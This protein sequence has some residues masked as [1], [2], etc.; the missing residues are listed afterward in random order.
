MA[1]PKVKLN[2]GF[3]GVAVIEIHNP[4]V[5]ALAP[6]VLLGLKVSFDEAHRRSDVKAIVVTGTNGKFSG[7]FD[8][9]AIVAVQEQG[10]MDSMVR[11]SVPLFVETIEG[12]S[13][14][15]VAAV[16]G[17]ALGGGLE[18]ALSC[19]ARIAAPKA[20]LGLPEL[21]LGIIPGFGG[22][23]RL[24]RLVGLQKAIEMILMSKPITSEAGLKAGLVDQIV[25]S[26]A[27]LAT[28]KAWA[29][30]IAS[31]R[32]PWLK[33]LERNDRI[34]SLGEA[35]AIFKFARAQ[36][37]QTAPNLTHP[38]RCLDAMEYGVTHGGYAGNLKEE[39]VFLELVL[40]DT[41]K[42]LTHIF[43]AQRQTTKVPG[44][45]DRGLKPRPIRKV[46]VIGGG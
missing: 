20:Q 13:K 26:N 37:V 40:A 6:E 32:K 36:A 31:G 12:G 21:Q 23:Q 16:E 11:P 33:T 38:L 28:A 41:A 27:L 46:A 34:E 2:V 22:T 29:L 9:S 8:I 43:F 17:L 4:P 15:V 19:H 10:N 45:T 30:D 3:D 14:P 18:L 25:P 44:V 24:P 35:R 1:T 39:E 5:N 42:S 7:G